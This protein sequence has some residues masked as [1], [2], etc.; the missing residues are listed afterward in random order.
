MFSK[1]AS[2]VVWMDASTAV[3]MADL[4]G[5]AQVGA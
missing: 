5:G 2:K 3:T 4:W 1:A